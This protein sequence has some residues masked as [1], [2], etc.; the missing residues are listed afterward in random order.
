M[1]IPE[2]YKRIS[3]GVI[4]G[5]IGLFVPNARRTASATCIAECEIYRIHKDKVLELFYQNPQFGFFIV[6]MLA[7]YLNES[8]DNIV[9]PG[10][11]V[12]QHLNYW[13]SGFLNAPKSEGRSDP[14]K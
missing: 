6:R 3:H 10:T 8:V 5:E 9:P 13:K 4:F 12:E 7:H 11:T 14:V 1:E 2:V